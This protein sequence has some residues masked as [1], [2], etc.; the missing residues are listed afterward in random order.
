MTTLPEP[1]GVLVIGY[2]NELRRD[3]GV[4]PWVAR[5]LVALGLP[6][7]RVRILHQL[8]PELAAELAET[9]LAIFID[10]QIGPSQEEAVALERLVPSENSEVLGHRVDPRALLTLASVYGR[11]PMAILVS[12]AGEDFG[13]GEGLSD[14]A[15]VNA[16]RA[17]CLV[18]NLIGQAMDQTSEVSETSEV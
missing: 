11:A 1:G 7:V 15:A 2:G 8:V 5:Q 9:R 10:A 4:G 16:R 12:V 3:D 17:L 14:F 18:Q 13:L 6:E